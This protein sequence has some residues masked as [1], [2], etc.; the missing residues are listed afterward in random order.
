MSSRIRFVLIAGAVLTLSL[1]GFGARAYA[2]PEPAP[3]PV[4][5]EYEF[6]HGKPT[7]IAVRGADRKYHWYW[8]M[9]YTVTNRTGDDRL[10]IPEVSV[11]TDKDDA[12]TPGKGVPANVFAAVK[13][14]LGNPLLTSPTQVV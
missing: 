14:K 11:A 8:Y 2:F 1:V 13:E 6:A 3:F 9:T 10:F 7:A 12:V 4:S 5:W